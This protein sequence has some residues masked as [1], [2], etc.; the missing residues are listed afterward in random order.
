MLASGHLGGPPI[1]ESLEA[2]L[3]ETTNL[4]EK[5]PEKLSELKKLFQAIDS[6]EKPLPPK[7]HAR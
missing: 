6:S 2:D 7:T 1:F 5:H 3:G 4:A